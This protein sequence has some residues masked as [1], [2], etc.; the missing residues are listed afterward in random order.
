VGTPILQMGKSD[1]SLSSVASD[2]EKAEWRHYEDDFLCH[3]MLDKAPWLNN[4]SFTESTCAPDA[5]SSFSRSSTESSSGSELE[6]H[7]DHAVLQAGLVDCNLAALVLDPNHFDFPIVAVSEGMSALTEYHQQEL[8]GKGCRLL[9]FNCGNDP[10]SIAN[11]RAT[12]SRGA[13]YQNVLINRKKSGQLYHVLLFLRRIA[14][15][16]NEKTGQDYGFLLGLLIELP[17]DGNDDNDHA[18]T[19]LTPELF[20]QTKDTADELASHLSQ[21]LQKGEDSPDFDLSDSNTKQCS[22][23]QVVKPGKLGLAQVGLGLAPLLT[24]RSALGSR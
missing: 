6:S 15:G 11:L 4:A 7:L 21:L 20:A 23:L 16:N 24:F 19:H 14:V 22:V 8:R 9:S 13:S 18:L 12:R 10:V 2:F 17:H 3:G 1:R 5:W